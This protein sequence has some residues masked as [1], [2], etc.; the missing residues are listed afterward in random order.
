[1]Q[2]SGCVSGPGAWTSALIHER[3]FT[4]QSLD[5]YNHCYMWADCVR[6]PLSLKPPIL[7]LPFPLS[8]SSPVLQKRQFESSN[9]FDG[10]VLVME[11]MTCCP[12]QKAPISVDAFINILLKALS[13]TIIA[14]IRVRK[15][16]LFFSSSEYIN[17]AR[18]WGIFSEVCF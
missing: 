4:A 6:F 8:L 16:C 1:M 2:R 13:E 7:I 11:V 12:L 10:S 5:I 9:W 14:G 17:E 18:S 15:T 3:L